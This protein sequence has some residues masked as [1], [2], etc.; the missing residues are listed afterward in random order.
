MQSSTPAWPHAINAHWTTVGAQRAGRQSQSEGQHVGPRLASPAPLLEFLPVSRD[1]NCRIVHR[2][3]GWTGRGHSMEAFAGWGSREGHG[4]LA[5]GLELIQRMLQRTGLRCEIG[6]GRGI[7]L[8][9]RRVLLR[10]LIHRVHGDVDFLQ[11]NR[12]L[13]RRLDNRS[14][15]GVDLADLLNDQFKRATS[16]SDEVNAVLDEM[17][18][19]K[20]DGRV[21]IKY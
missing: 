4:H 14:N 18:H 7:L 19:A 10:R 9:H 15:I 11:A 12:L 2:S 16:L 13:A 1:R 20:I 5:P 3:N 17:K 21:V 8:G 6:A